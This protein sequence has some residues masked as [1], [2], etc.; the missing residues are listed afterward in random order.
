MIRK[1]GPESWYPIRPWTVLELTGSRLEPDPAGISRENHDGQSLSR[2][3]KPV[4]FRGSLDKSTRLPI[5]LSGS[6]SPPGSTKDRIQ[7]CRRSR[8]LQLGSR[9]SMGAYWNSRSVSCNDASVSVHNVT[10]TPVVGSRGA[11]P[12]RPE[13]FPPI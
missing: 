8:P 1:E 13:Q 12:H 3:G 7:A 4:A 2:W 6:D 11:Y 5:W 9:E 10:S